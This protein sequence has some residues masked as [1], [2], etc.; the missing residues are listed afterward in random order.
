MASQSTLI[1][2]HI[3]FR[4]ILWSATGRSGAACQPHLLTG[5]APSLQ[6]KVMCKVTEEVVFR[7]NHCTVEGA[8]MLSKATSMNPVATTARSELD[9]V[10]GL[11]C[12]RLLCRH[13]AEGLCLGCVL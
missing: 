2:G 4:Q 10:Q 1:Q 6:V 13:L 7:A 3:P 11:R 12:L 8:R 9:I 5:H